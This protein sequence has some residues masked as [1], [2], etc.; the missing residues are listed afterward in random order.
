MSATIKIV[1]QKDI[2]RV[3]L[4][5]EAPFKKLE[6]AIGRFYPNEFPNG[7]YVRYL[8][9]EEDY[10]TVTCDQELLDALELSSSTLKLYLSAKTESDSDSDFV[11]VS[12]DGQRSG[13]LNNPPTPKPEPESQPKYVQPEEVKEDKEV[14]DKVAKEA[15][16]VVETAEKEAAIPEVDEKVLKAIKKAK[17]A[18]DKAEKR[19]KKAE[20]L[21]KNE[22][23]SKLNCRFLKDVTIPDEQEVELGSNLEK[24]W[25]VKNDGKVAWPEGI[26][27][28]KFGK[29]TVDSAQDCKVPLLQPGETGHIAVCCVVPN[30]VGKFKSQNYS[31]SYNGKKFGD[32]FW[33]IVRATKKAA[34]AEVKSKSKLPKATPQKAAAK[35]K[36]TRKSELGAHFIKDLNFPDDCV[37]A[38]GQVIEKEW[39][40]KNTGDIAWPKGTKLVSIHGSTFGT[41]VSVDIKEQV[42]VGEVYKLRTRLV[43]PTKTGKHTAK[44]MLSFEGQTFGHKY[45]VNVCVSKF[46][47]KAQLMD[48]AKEF[49]ADPA[50]VG[51]L[52]GELP[53]ILKDL[54]N[55]KKLAT[56]VDALAEKEPHLMEHSFMVFIRPFLQSVESFMG[57]QLEAAIGMYSLWAMTPFTP[58]ATQKNEETKTPEKQAKNAEKKPNPSQPVNV[59]K[60]PHV[61]PK[62]DQKHEDKQLG[63]EDKKNTAPAPAPVDDFGFPLQV[64]TLKDMGFKNLE[65]IKPLLIKHN[66]NTQAVLAELFN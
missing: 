1:F 59:E 3:A 21:A 53:Q 25:L 11:K 4:P 33:I 58:G 57:M 40:I 5:Q 31:L 17:K 19:A 44:F 51:V 63:G 61:N 22:F 9:D 37:V 24:V 23:F 60:S 42:K 26:K 52:Q 30:R 50:V 12:K 62:A 14:V 20:K 13:L 56:I 6:D 7:V 27:L 38:P 64:K 36:R 55:G 48:L 16:K 66:G 65:V 45:W 10:V 8:D 18:A 15:D 35:P 28:V 2:R 34:K 29:G 41:D 32:R 54:R 39:L 47:N 49:I 43:V 46:P